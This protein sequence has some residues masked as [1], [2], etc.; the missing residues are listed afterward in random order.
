MTQQV[1]FEV[2]PLE[3]VEYSALWTRVTSSEQ[4]TIQAFVTGKSHLE[5]D[6]INKSQTFCRVLRP[7][8]EYRQVESCERA[9]KKL[10]NLGVCG[11]H[12]F[13]RALF[14]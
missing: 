13:L 8:E 1:L 9:S 6:I 5:L 2:K 4:S 3:A 11:C 14:S 12:T 7:H 10:L